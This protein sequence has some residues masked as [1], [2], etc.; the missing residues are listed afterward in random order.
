MAWDLEYHCWELCCGYL[1][2][3][4]GC[5]NLSPSVD[6]EGDAVLTQSMLDLHFSNRAKSSMFGKKMGTWHL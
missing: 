6:A 4:T 1:A 3:Q 5:L 2:L